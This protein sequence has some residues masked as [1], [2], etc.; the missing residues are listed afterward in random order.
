MLFFYL[1]MTQKN[2]KNVKCSV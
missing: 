2:P 1:T